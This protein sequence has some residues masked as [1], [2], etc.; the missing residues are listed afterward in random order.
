MKKFPLVVGLLVAFA[1]AASASGVIV[2]P[3][4]GQSPAQQEKDKGACMSWASDQTGFDPTAPL[5]DNPPPRAQEPTSSVGGG[6]LRGALLGTAIGAISGH[7]G[8]GAAIGAG[9]GALIGGVRRQNQVEHAYEQQDRWAAQQADQYAQSQAQFN[10]AYATCM[11]G[12][13]YAVN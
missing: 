4:Q 11:Q 8:K 13:G 1:S 6:M 9:S 7:A 5:P 10:R 12:R 3:S 2:Y